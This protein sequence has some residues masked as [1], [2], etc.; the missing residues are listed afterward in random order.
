MH[1]KFNGPLKCYSWN[2]F[3]MHYV[4]LY[5]EGDTVTWVVGLVSAVWRRDAS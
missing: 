2:K 4:M 5:T 1:F 3:Y